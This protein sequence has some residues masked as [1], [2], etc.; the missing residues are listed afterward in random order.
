MALLE[1]RAEF[2]VGDAGIDGGRRLFAEVLNGLH[3]FLR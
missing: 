1:W 3:R 2:D